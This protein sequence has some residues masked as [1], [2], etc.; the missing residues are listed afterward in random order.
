[1]KG[2]PMKIHLEGEVKPTRVLTARQIPVHLR[3]SAAEIVKI[4]LD[5]GVI[6]PV[7]EPTEWI[8]PAFFVPKPKGAPG[9]S[10]TSRASTGSCG[11]RCTPSPAPSSCYNAW[12][13]RRRSSRRSTRCRVPPDTAR[14]RELIADHLHTAVGKVQVHEGAHGPQRLQRRVV[15]AFG[16]RPRRGGRRPKDRR[17]HPHLGRRRTAAA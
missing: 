6:V 9:S 14:L 17:R 12:G 13:T 11:D 3:E 4:T 8:S 10:A 1:M 16:R 2:K 15:R 7:N 5:S